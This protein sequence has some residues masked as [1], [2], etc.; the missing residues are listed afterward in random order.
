MKTMRLL[1]W[2]QGI[3]TLATAIWPL[4]HIESFMQVTGHKTDIWLVKTVG[5]LLI[6]VALC[7]MSSLIIR[8]DPRPILI[9]GALT[10]ISFICI[11]FYYSLTDVISNI[12][13]ADGL[14]QI[15][16]LITWIYVSI[17]EISWRANPTSRT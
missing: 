15:L 3:Y 14:L 6:P 13:M 7:L 2:T 5:A 8:I 16:L 17:K 9:L 10:T 4:L 1:V 11:D 12:Y